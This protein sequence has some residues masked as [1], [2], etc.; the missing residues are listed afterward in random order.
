MKRSP[1]N[2][3]FLQQYMRVLWADQRKNAAFLGFQQ[4]KAAFQMKIVAIARKHGSR[5][6]I[7]NRITSMYDM[8][9]PSI[10]G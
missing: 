2:E 5:A 10:E 7:F 6:A 8:I 1:V 4:K 3:C 9:R